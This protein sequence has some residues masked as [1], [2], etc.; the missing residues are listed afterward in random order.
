MGTAR[1]IERRREFRYP[2]SAGVRVELRSDELRG[3][4]DA[5]VVNISKNGFGVIV[6]VYVA[7]HTGIVF[8]FGPKKVFA[9]VRYCRKAPGGYE[10]GLLIAAVLEDSSYAAAAR[11]M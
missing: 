2:I 4:L 9:N 11:T 5:E 8:Q 3:P 6:A 10:I 7:P 1:G